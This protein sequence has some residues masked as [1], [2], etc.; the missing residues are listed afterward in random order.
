M[1]CLSKDASKMKSKQDAER[2]VK[3]KVSKVDEPERS[4]RNRQ[5]SCSKSTIKSL[6]SFLFV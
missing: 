2:K 5:A 1:E 4:K 3:I 6:V